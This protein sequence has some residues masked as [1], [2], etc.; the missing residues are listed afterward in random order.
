MA[1]PSSRQIQ[2]VEFCRPNLPFELWIASLTTADCSTA[3]GGRVAIEVLTKSV[4]TSDRDPGALTL[5]RRDA[6]LPR[7]GNVGGKFERDTA[8]AHLRRST[9]PAQ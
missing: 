3:E 9:Q 6:T 2:P 8:R 7:P 4:F 1:G 5:R